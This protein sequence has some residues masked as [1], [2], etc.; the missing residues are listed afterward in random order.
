M[1][2]GS[3]YG[4]NALLG[5]KCFSLRIASA[6][7]RDD[8]WLAEHMLILGITNPQGIKKYFVAAFPSACG[9]TNLAMLNPTLPGWKVETVGD[10]IA[11]MKY[12]KDG[13]LYAIN[14]ENGFFG[15]A[16][17]TSNK[18]NPN[19]MSTINTNTLF[20]N[21]ALTPEG[22]VW[23]EGMTDK[24]PEK[25]TDWL[26]NEWT[27]TAGRPAAHP[28]SRFTAPVGQC[29]TIDPRWNDPEGVP[30]EAIIFGG[31][32]STTVPL[33]YQAFNWK[34][35]TFMG[36]SVASEQTAA[37]EGKL[38]SLRHDPFAMIPFCGYN[39]ANY[40]GHWLDVGKATD[41]RK[42]PDIF[43]VNW[44]KK[45][46]EGKFLWPGFGEN[47]RVL[48]WIFERSHAKSEEGAVKTPIGY[49]P[50][51]G[52]LDISGL[53]L[54][55]EV[56]KE[57]FKIDKAEWQ[58]DLASLRKFLSQFGDNV[59]KGIVEETNALEQRLNQL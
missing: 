57:L 28:N 16:P 30:I 42:L 20:T 36:A 8:G 49:V 7:A 37:A 38:G 53:G 4:G 59:P 12:G 33:V 11:W 1:S 51:E 21:V 50:K 6:M 52:A 47:S 2:Y 5:K 19:A 48:K 40:F 22:D 26:G 55:P 29:P 32:R 35:G 31:R 43:F 9:K 58:S 46:P 54:K 27:P 44:F 17:G 39:M 24:V 45:S 25:L 3:G 34:H 13:R 56:M 15:V 23:W 14:P 41:P 18:S 10:D